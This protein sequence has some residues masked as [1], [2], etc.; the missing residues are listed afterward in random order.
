[1]AKTKQVEKTAG[2]ETVPEGIGLN[3]NSSTYFANS[4]GKSLN[5]LPLLGDNKGKKRLP[6][7][8]KI[9]SDISEKGEANYMDYCYGP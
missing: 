6:A 7:G 5:G 2:I 3:P 1:M 9:Y 8:Y 4:P